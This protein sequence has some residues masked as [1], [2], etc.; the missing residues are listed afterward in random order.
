MS[1]G[2]IAGQFKE[3]SLSVVIGKGGFLMGNFEKFRIIGQK[4]CYKTG[5]LIK[6]VGELGNGPNQFQKPTGCTFHN[7]HYYVI[8]SGNKRVVILDRQ[9][10]Y[11]D[12]LPLPKS[13]RE[14]EKEFTDIAI[15]DKG[16][17]YVSG[18]FLFDSGIYRYDVKKKKKFENI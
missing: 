9:F 14:S 7:G 3:P 1:Y 11:I 4:T 12:D 2:C 17:I 13:D 6:S 8:D 16:D 5:N 18:D 15:N 10:N